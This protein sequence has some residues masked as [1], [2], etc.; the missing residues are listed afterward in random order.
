VA[1]I[2]D[3]RG[4]PWQRRSK[5]NGPQAHGQEPHARILL[6]DAVGEL[7]HWWGIAQIA[8][9]GGSLTNRGG[10]NMIE[11][12]AYGAAVSFGPNIWNF[13]DVVSLMIE[14]NAAVI[15]RDEQQ[16]ENFVRRCLVD[17]AFADELGCNAKE[18]VRQ[19]QGAADRSIELLEQL[20]I[21]Q[22][23]A[24]LADRAA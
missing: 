15:V 23:K 20:V 6:V 9:V 2:L 3:R 18:L 24:E 1:A 4:V 16:L 14:R 21:S 11:P 17:S 19:Q 10:Q 7:G 22:S 12:A 8:F 5:L 13:W